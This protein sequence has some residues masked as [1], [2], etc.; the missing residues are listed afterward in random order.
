MQ[1]ALVIIMNYAVADF[2]ALS[3]LASL[4]LYLLLGVS[5]IISFT[6]QQ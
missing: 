6:E 4:L 1:K 3:I 2:K 5:S